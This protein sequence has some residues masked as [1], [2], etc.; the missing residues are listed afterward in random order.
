MIGRWGQS[1]PDEEADELKG[2]DDFELRLGDIM[3]GERAT[4]GKSLLDVQR[5]LKIKAAYVAAIENADPSAFETP[6]FIAGFV[7]SYARYLG[8]D[9]EWAFARFSEESGFTT[10][11]GMSADALPLRKAR[12]DRPTGRPASEALA[13]PSVPFRPSEVSAFS[14][15]EPR[16]IGSSAVLVALIMGLGYGAWSVL[17]EVQRVELA[18]IDQ[19]PSVSSDVADLATGFGAA[20]EGPELAATAPPP[21]TD[22]LERLYRP[23]ALDVPV[24]V[25]R[26]APIATLDPDSQG[27]FA[28]GPRLAGIVPDGSVQVVDGTTPEITLIATSPTWVRV[29]TPGNSVVFEKILAPGEEYAIPVTEETPVLRAG[30]AGSLYFRVNG[31]LVGPAGDGGTV[32]EDVLLASTDLSAAFAPANPLEDSALFDLLEELGSTA[33]LPRQAALLNDIG[34]DSVSLVTTSESWVR[35]RDENGSV[36]FEGTVLRGQIQDLPEGADAALLSRAGNS[37]ELYFRV[38]DLFFGPAGDDGA[39]VTNIGLGAD[40]IRDRYPLVDAEALGFTGN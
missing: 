5:E 12:E 23:A 18:P 40:D 26:D 16:A 30:N 32:V 10:A 38:G 8:L 20:P 29:Q 1:E 19:A 31:E 9:P 14:G 2:F 11:H 17:Q 36:S 24:M 34:G 33:V 35:I 28:A 7:R 4:L 3:R 21:S 37:G 13:A 6:G 15:I 27:L 22:A 39:I 25:A